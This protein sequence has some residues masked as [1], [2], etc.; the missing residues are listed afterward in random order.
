[1]WKQAYFRKK[2]GAPISIQ[3]DVTVRP[4]TP[5][6]PGVNLGFKAWFRRVFE[7]NPARAEAEAKGV[8]ARLCPL[9]DPPSR[10]RQAGA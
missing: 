6:N 9:A 10:D 4:E 7:A 3:S 8:A 5:E 2:I 1:M